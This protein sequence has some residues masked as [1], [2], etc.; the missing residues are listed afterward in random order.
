M[1]SSQL[2]SALKPHLA[3][4]QKPEEGILAA[5][6]VIIYYSDG[7][8]HI[9]LTKRSNKLRN[10]GG[11]ISC[12]GGTYLDSDKDLLH[13]AIRETREEI[14]IR[15]DERDIVGYLPSV[16]TLTSNFAIVPYVAIINAIENLKP[17][18]TEIDE[19]ID[20]SLI[21]LLKTVETDLD[22][23][24]FGEVFRFKCNGNIVWGATAKILKQIYDILHK[25]GMI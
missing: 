2:L 9:L 14:G 15:I 6:L 16:H 22:H 24:S 4:E 3:K 19:V 1:E 17:N 25:S 12:P 5:V 21:D 23:T 11:E 20:T 10:H 18:V 7:K 13:T 8:P